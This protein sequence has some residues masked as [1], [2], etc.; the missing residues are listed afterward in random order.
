[1]GIFFPFSNKDEEEEQLLCKTAS[2]CTS[3]LVSVAPSLTATA[4]GAG[5]GL[6]LCCAAP[7]L[8]LS[9]CFCTRTEQ[10]LKGCLDIFNDF[11]LASTSHQGHTQQQLCTD[12]LLA[13]VP[14]W[15]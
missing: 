7:V 15:L 11:C 5:N 13:A 1:M 8:T 14:R 6:Q 4:Q 10:F 3:E 12:L 2:R 9:S